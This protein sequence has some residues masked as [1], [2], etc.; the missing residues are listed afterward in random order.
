MSTFG[1]KE[2]KRGEI[3]STKVDIRECDDKNLA[4]ALAFR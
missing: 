2:K 4:C 3:L 1:D